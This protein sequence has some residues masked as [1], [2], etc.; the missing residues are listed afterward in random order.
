MRD[1]RRRLD[2]DRRR[3]GPARRATLDRRRRA[4]RRASSRD[5]AP[6]RSASSD[7]SRRPA[8]VT[9]RTVE[10]RPRRRDRAARR[11]G[12]R[13]VRAAQ[14]RDH[15]LVG[16]DR[17]RSRLPSR[18]VRPPR[19][20]DRRRR[21]LPELPAAGGRR[22]PV[23][24]AQ[25]LRLPRRRHRRARPASSTE[26]SPRCARGCPRERAAGGRS[27]RRRG[28]HRALHAVGSDTIVAMLRAARAALADARSTGQT[29][30]LQVV[31]N[32]GARPAPGRTTCAWTCTTC[33]RSRIASPRSWAAPPASSSARASARGAG[34]SGRGTADRTGSSGE[35]DAT[36]RLRAV[37]LTLAVRG[38][39]RPAPPRRGLRAG[40]RPDIAATAEALRQVL[41]R[42]R[43]DPRWAALQPRPPHRAAAR[44]G[45]RDLPLALGDPPASARDRRA[46]AREPACRSIRSRPEDA[47]EELLGRTARGGPGEAPG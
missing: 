41:G 21:R 24:D 9:P 25:G 18:P 45:R 1:A 13:P 5:R 26:A 37:R 27:W 4:G 7:G 22:R 14:G 42:A 6:R 38:L 11:G 3:G 34:S 17:R 47:V 28:E 32:W 29:D 19:R 12:R 20:A 8:P 31:Q 43:R 33:P 30:H 40:R 10:R 2:L 15:R 36:R 35:D 16:R 23:A 39:G 44:A 46:R